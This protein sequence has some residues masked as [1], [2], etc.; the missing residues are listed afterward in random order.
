[1]QNSFMEKNDTFQRKRY[2]R[3]S[4]NSKYDKKLQYRNLVLVVN[5]ENLE[6]ICRSLERNGLILENK[7]GEGASA[8]VYCARSTGLSG[9]GKSSWQGERG[10]LHAVKILKYSDAHTSHESQK[11]KFA[12]EKEIH[13]QLNHR[14]ITSVH[15]KEDTFMVMEFCEGGSLFDAFS[16]KN[17][18]AN[19]VLSPEY[20]KKLYEGINRNM[21][22]L[23]LPQLALDIIEALEHI[24][25]MGFA[26][27][28][29]KSSN[30]LL[31]W[32]DEL[33]R[34]VAKVCDFG[35]ASHL[36]DLPFR[37]KRSRIQTIVGTKKG[38]FYPIGSLLWMPPEMLDP[39]TE[40]SNNYCR[41]DK[42]DVYACGVVFWEMMEWRIPWCE[43]MLPT[44]QRVIQAVVRNSEIHLPFPAKISPSFKELLIAMLQKDPRNRPDSSQVVVDLIDIEGN[45]DTSNSFTDVANFLGASR[46][47]EYAIFQV[48][49]SARGADF[50]L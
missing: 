40:S 39:P 13:C 20:D 49:A 36:S 2:R 28:D 26:H 12:K 44:R 10:K 43:E 35:S 37:K 38:S 23:N 25:K 22:M 47:T 29:L 27:R 32:N 1:M 15:Y 4:K 5:S 19:Q 50:P 21:P 45:W 41:A 9:F 18:K 14:N 16:F 24:H 6:D 17:I 31:T 42:V 48:L 34:T 7:V 8:S 33:Q 11:E 3:C 30:I 46:K